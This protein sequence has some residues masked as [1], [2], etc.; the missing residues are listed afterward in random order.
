MLMDCYAQ[1]ATA[2]LGLLV[3]T[4][5]GERTRYASLDGVEEDLLCWGFVGVM[6]T[7]ANYVLTR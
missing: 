5:T 1:S 7:A 6:T 3:K 2:F 4:W